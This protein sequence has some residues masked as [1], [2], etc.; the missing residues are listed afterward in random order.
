M[1][2]LYLVFKKSAQNN[3]ESFVSWCAGPMVHV[4]LVLGDS[5]IMFTSYM[6]ERFSMNLSVGYSP[7]TH[8]ALALRVSQEEYSA[9]EHLVLE[10]FGRNIPYNYSDVFHLILPSMTT[11]QD[12]DSPADIDS[13]FCSQA[14][15]LALRMGLDCKHPL[16]APLCA[17]NSRCTTPTMLYDVLKSHCEAVDSII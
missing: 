5:R 14:V 6:F 8:Q 17:L 10:F 1:P 4:D 9:V 3:M 16:H 2:T 7:D 11:V 15:T 12:V 13:L